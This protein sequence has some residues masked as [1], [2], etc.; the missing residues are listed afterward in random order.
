MKKF[1][2]KILHKIIEGEFK[3]IE[4]KNF[5]IKASCSVH[6]SPE[7]L[8]SNES[9]RSKVFHKYKTASLFLKFIHH[10]SPL[11]ARNFSPPFEKTSWKLKPITPI[12]Q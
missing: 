5:V 12:T 11:F 1:H 6:T 10:I 4:L 3:D 9:T 7:M 8:F 2:I